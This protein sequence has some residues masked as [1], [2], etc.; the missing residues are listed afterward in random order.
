M[1]TV[2]NCYKQ[3]NCKIFSRPLQL[4]GWIEHGEQLERRKYCM[5]WCFYLEQYIWVLLFISGVFIGVLKAFKTKARAFELQLKPVPAVVRMMICFQENGRRLEL[6]QCTTFCQN[7][8]FLCRQL[9]VGHVQISRSL[10]FFNKRFFVWF[11]TTRSKGT[12]STC[13]TAKLMDFQGLD[14]YLKPTL[15]HNRLMN[16][17]NV[18]NVYFKLITKM[19]L[20]RKKES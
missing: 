20:L 11:G 16:K 6:V 4:G 5:I 7:Q 3:N 19:L 10:T 9:I 18:T 15:T 8:H 2:I 17:P 12:C 13:Q 1:L 14:H